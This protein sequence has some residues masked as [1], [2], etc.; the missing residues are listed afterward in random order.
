MIKTQSSDQSFPSANRKKLH[1]V[2]GLP[3]PEHLLFQ[4]NRR[5]IHSFFRERTP[6]EQDAVESPPDYSD[7]I[8]EEK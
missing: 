5:H 4:N 8:S 7:E 3:L 6:G 1:Q 2:A